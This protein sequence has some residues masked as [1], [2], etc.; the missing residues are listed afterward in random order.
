MLLVHKLARQTQK[1]GGKTGEFPLQ[2]ARTCFAMGAFW[3]QN[4]LS[5][6]V[7]SFVPYHGVI[8]R[9]IIRLLHL[10]YGVLKLYHSVSVGS[11]PETD[12]VLFFNFVIFEFLMIFFF[13]FTL[14]K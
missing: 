12:E 8:I 11:S 6:T 13:D 3:G 4:R 10:W 9:F 14:V 1:Q 2:C 7:L 5:F